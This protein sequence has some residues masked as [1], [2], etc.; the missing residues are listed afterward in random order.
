MEI[1]ISIP[2]PQTVLDAITQHETKKKTQKEEFIKQATR[3][4]EDYIERHFNEWLNECVEAMQ[5]THNSVHWNTCKIPLTV[6]WLTAKE[7]TSYT[8]EAINILKNTI[9]AAINCFNE[10]T[11]KNIPYYK[12]K[13]D[14]YLNN[15]WNVKRWVMGVELDNGNDNTNDIV[16]HNKK[17]RD[18]FETLGNYLW[19]RL[20]LSVCKK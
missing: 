3:R 11:P 12:L 1:N 17:I 2:P 5:R 20:I 4:V 8:E 18:S 15:D 19:F 10:S 9:T 14:S 16:Y 13:E 7:F 6:L